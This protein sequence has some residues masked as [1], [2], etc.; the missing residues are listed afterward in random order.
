ML[1]FAWTMTVASTKDQA[2]HA[3]AFA[4][5]LVHIY[6]CDVTSDDAE[7]G[8][9]EHVVYFD[10]RTTMGEVLAA[11]FGEMGTNEP[12]Y[13]FDFGEHVSEAITP[14]INH[15]IAINRNRFAVYTCSNQM[16]CVWIVS[17]ASLGLS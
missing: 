4:Q 10:A 16:H 5:L 14:E 3:D 13:M 7:R 15:D 1:D 12:N 17:S 9:V 8:F 2:T 11:V 6:V